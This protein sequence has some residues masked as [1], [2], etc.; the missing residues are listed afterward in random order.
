MSITD[1]IKKTVL[2]GFTET[3]ISTTSIL[4]TLL[5]SICLGLFIYFVYRVN[6]RNGFYN[7]SFNKALASMPMLTA[8]IM[9]AMQSSFLI[10]LGMVGALSIV[11]FR[12]AVKD[13]ADLTYLFWSVSMGIIVGATQYELAIMLSLCMAFLTFFMDMLPAL[14]APCLLVISAES[15]VEEQAV[16]ECVHKYCPKAKMRNRSIKKNGREWILELQTRQGEQLVKTVS[17]VQGIISVNLISHDG[18]V[19]F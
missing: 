19:R 14:R 2:R 12:N 13:A 17:E 10:S 11:R 15:G 7:R 18:D 5:V 4:V 1:T 9:L 6:T 3:N 16:L 8:G